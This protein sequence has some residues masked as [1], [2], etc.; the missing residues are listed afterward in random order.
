[1]TKHAGHRHVFIH[2]T[3]ALIGLSIVF[4][5]VAL[6]QSTVS[7]NLSPTI[8]E[9]K[10]VP[11]ESRDFSLSVE[12]RGDTEMSLTPFARNI[13]GMDASR[14][15]VYATKPEE[16]TFDLAS[17]IT[18]K[19]SRIVLPPGGGATLNFTVHFPADAR[20]GSHMAGL[21]VSQAAPEDIKLGSGIGFEVASILHFQMTGDIVEDTRIREFLSE[22]FV[23]GS[24]DVT[25]RIAVE[26]LGNT[27]S[28]PQGVID[29]TDMFGKKV[30]MLPVNKEGS[31]VFPGDK[32][33]YLIRW[34]PEGL[35]LGRFD[36]VLALAVPLVDG[37]NQTI[38]S[39][40]QFWVLP[41]KILG[42]IL[43]GLLAFV[44][45]F[46]VLLKLYIRK[47]LGELRGGR[48]VYREAP[49]GVS[50]MTAIVIALLVALVLGFTLLFFLA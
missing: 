11:G 16:N 36:A 21:F 48:V 6:A 15:P 12:N 3:Q 8:I 38:S 7:V 20:P 46:Y 23:Y 28:R 24:P 34:Q 2:I 43:A 47:Q 17:W 27:F 31:G 19:E 35:T 18:F 42:P 29:I 1:M 13:I 44:I 4:P 40:T 37:G 45:V 30:A 50:R 25:F 32:R 14:L 41:M 39:V 26:N 33:D 10:V 22:R 5:V 49:G 9:E